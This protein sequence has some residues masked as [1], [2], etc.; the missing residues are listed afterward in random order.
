MSPS[1][2]TSNRA[3]AALDRLVAAFASNE[4]AAYFGC[5]APTARFVF[6][7]TPEVALGVEQYRTLWRG[8]RSEGWRVDKCVST[9]RDVLIVGDTAIVTHRV[10]TT[11]G[12]GTELSERETVV[13]DLATSPHPLVVHEHLSA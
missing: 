7:D 13:F 11:L 4:E 1:D 2:N 12:D 6:P 3:L 5:C 9:E 8:W 10:S